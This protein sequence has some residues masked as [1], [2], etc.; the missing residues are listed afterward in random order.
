MEIIQL[1]FKQN[2]D[3]GLYEATTPINQDVKLQVV[4]ESGVLGVITMS[5]SL[6]NV[7]WD[8]IDRS[9]SSNSPI[10]QT[11]GASEGD[12]IKIVADHLVV[13]SICK[14]MT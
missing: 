11:D 9:R 13:N 8:L 7:H 14:T 10:L 12:Y 2:S 5:R 3:T 4:F 6:D 1:S